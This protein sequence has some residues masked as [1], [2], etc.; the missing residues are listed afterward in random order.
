[1][2]AQRSKLRIIEEIDK[3]NEDI[4]TWG[5]STYFKNFVDWV[6]FMQ[7]LGNRHGWSDS[8]EDCSDEELEDKEGL[9]FPSL[10]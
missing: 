10:T 7:E 1:M 6:G 4:I 9:G 5:K 8:K 3:Q 2:E